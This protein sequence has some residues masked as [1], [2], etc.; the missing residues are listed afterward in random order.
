MARVEGADRHERD[1][2]H[3]HDGGPF[4]QMPSVI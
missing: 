2:G 3:E 4:F 1:E